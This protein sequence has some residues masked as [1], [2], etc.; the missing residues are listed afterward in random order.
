M[1]LY[2]AVTEAVRH[3]REK[4]KLLREALE[5]MRSSRPELK[6]SQDKPKKPTKR[7]NKAA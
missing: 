2:P 3:A 1:I 7:Q 5:L 6:V 4:N